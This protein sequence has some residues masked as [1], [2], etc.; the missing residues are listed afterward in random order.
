M[1]TDIDL[2]LGTTLVTAAGAI[3]WG[4]K[5]TLGSNVLA[6]VIGSDNTGIAY[7]VIGLAGVVT[8]TERFELTEI[9][10]E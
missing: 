3:N 1:D 4:A 5:E 7:L 9:F 6:D 8:V 2:E 10:E